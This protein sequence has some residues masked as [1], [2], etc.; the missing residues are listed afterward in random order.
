VYYQGSEKYFES[1]YHLVGGHGKIIILNFLF[2]NY[3]LFQN[4]TSDSEYKHEY[5]RVHTEFV[6]LYFCMLQEDC[7]HT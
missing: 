6:F 5:T 4:N 2:K 1:K 7:I 3:K